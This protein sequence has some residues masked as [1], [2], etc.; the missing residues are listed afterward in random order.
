MATRI[1]LFYGHGVRYPPHRTEHV[2]ITLTLGAIAA[3]LIIVLHLIVPYNTGLF[4]PPGNF[5][6]CDSELGDSVWSCLLCDLPDHPL[7]GCH[8]K[9][10]LHKPVQPMRSMV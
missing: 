9:P 4:L 1:V 10:A 8:G 2:L 5:I 7:R 3:A 6:E